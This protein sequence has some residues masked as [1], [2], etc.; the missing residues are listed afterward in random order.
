M[1]LNKIITN[2]ADHKTKL[3]GENI[4]NNSKLDESGIYLPLFPSRTNLKLQNISVTP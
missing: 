3:F 4:S 2:A 1:A